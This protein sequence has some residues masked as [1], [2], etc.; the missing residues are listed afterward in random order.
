MI[1]Q[2][3]IRAPP[4]REQLQ[5]VRASDLCDARAHRVHPTR[6]VHRQHAQDHR[7]HEQDSELHHVRVRHREQAREQRID[8]RDPPEHQQNLSVT[9][10]QNRRERLCEPGRAVPQHHSGPRE[11]RVHREDPPEDRGRLSPVPYF[12][13]LPRGHHPEPAPHLRPDDRD[14]RHPD[15]PADPP[16]EP[17]L[18]EPAHEHEHDPGGPTPRVRGYVRHPDDPPGKLTSRDKEILSTPTRAPGEVHPDP[19]RGRAIYAEHQPVR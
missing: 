11:I 13:Q 12:D 3:R 10:S 6:R 18:H 9:P 2:R 17:Q 4:R 16:H 1:S 7:P 19:Q 5:K 14:D 8:Q 15:R